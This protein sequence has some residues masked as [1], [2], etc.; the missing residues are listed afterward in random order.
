MSPACGF[1][2]QIS[3]LG[4]CVSA[5]LLSGCVTV[6]GS[7]H[8][9][10]VA[11]ARFGATEVA[12]ESVKVTIDYVPQGDI[13]SQMAAFARSSLDGL[14]RASRSGDSR[15]AVASIEVNQRS[16]LRGI[17]PVNSI[18]I[19]F[20]VTDDQGVVLLRAT[21]Y[22]VG[23]ES[24]LSAAVQRALIREITIPLRGLFPRGRVGRDGRE[25]DAP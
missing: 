4:F 20:T 16:M 19:S 24:A 25:S 10:R 2:A 1:R 3:V 5:A 22:W 21:R 18:F 6:G 23:K 11:L 9:D 17:E 8:A 14:R 13:A 7:M 15:V 12:L